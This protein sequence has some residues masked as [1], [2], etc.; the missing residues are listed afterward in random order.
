MPKNDKKKKNAQKARKGHQ[1]VQRDVPLAD[2]CQGYAQVE[3]KLGNRR[4]KIGCQDG[5]TRMG[6][7]RGSIRKRKKTWVK[8]GAWVIYAERIG[9]TAPKGKDLEKVDIIQILSDDEVRRLE[10]MG[11]ITKDDVSKGDAELGFVF[12]DEEDGAK[13]VIDIDEI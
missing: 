6:H 5:I 9:F 1:E 2:V 10:I 12:D 7:L 11:E 3:E 8:V 13:V 4:F